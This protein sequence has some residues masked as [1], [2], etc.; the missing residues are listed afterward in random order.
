MWAGARGGEWK[1]HH[2]GGEVIGQ[3]LE[4]ESHTVLAALACQFS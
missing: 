4:T 2:P 1:R 3:I